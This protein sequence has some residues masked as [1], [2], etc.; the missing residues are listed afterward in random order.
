MEHE[1]IL[2]LTLFL[3]VFVLMALW[4]VFNPRRPLTQSKSRRW[5]SNIS[6]VIINT[7]VLRLL[8]PTATLGAALYAQ[9]QN[10]GIFNISATPAIIATVLS[11][12]LLDLLIYWQHRLVH[13]VP[14][15]W[16]FHRVHHVDPDLD[17]TSGSRFHP[18]EILFSMLIKVTAIL[19]LG[20][21]PIAA[22]IFEAILS[23]MAMFNH[24]NVNIPERLDRWLRVLLVTPDM[25]RVH[26]S[27]EWRETNSNYGFNLSWWDRLF[28][29]Y[30]P[31]PDSGQLA[32][33][34]GVKGISNPRTTTNLIGMLFLPF[35]KNPQ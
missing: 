32:M 11:I 1:P 26:H 18:V 16:R 24:S 19:L 10:W 8:F 17:I 29:S 34:L 2:R 14:L 4:E 30:K 28:A 15:F 35:Q 22:L 27:V 31:S 13:V 20:V 5:F 33:I 3:S 12:L 23:S 6:L 25:H 9:E 21:P 7:I